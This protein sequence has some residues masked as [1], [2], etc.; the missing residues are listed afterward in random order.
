MQSTHPV[1]TLGLLNVMPWEAHG[2]HR[3]PASGA[4]AVPVGYRAG[5]RLIY[6]P[7][8]HDANLAMVAEMLSGQVEVHREWV[9]RTAR[10]ERLL[11]VHGDQFDAEMAYAWLAGFGNALYDATVVINDRLND[12]RRVIG[13]R[14]ARRSSK[15]APASC[16]CCAGCTRDTAASRRCPCWR[17]SPRE[18]LS[19]E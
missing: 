6:I 16:G 8:N 4:D 17:R 7:G 11:V 5:A 9:H 13:W 10:G 3:F 18:L 12:V 1:R 15:K 14:R 2:A 19:T